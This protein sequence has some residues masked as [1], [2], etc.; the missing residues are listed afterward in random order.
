M[1]IGIFKVY[2]LTF[3]MLDYILRTGSLGEL[4]QAFTSLGK[5]CSEQHCETFL[6]EVIVMGQYVVDATLAHCMHRNTIRQAVAFVGPCFVK[7]ETGHECLVALRRQ[8]DIRAAENSLSLGD[9]STASLLANSE[10]KFKSSTSTSS[11]VINLVSA[12][13]LL[14]VMARSCHWS[15]GLKRATK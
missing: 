3:N 1:L 6:P 5:A 2:G 10:K 7:G 9:C 13:S 11:V 15:L 8:L 4:G 14:A 12:T